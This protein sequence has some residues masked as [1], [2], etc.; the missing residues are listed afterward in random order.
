L[1]AA[2]AHKQQV[3]GFGLIQ[4]LPSADVERRL[5]LLGMTRGELANS[6]A[7]G[8]R[9][10]IL[11]VID[12]GVDLSAVGELV[13][14]QQTATPALGQIAIAEVVSHVAID[15]NGTDARVDFERKENVRARSNNTARN[16]AGRI[17]KRHMGI[18]GDAEVGLLLRRVG[19]SG[20]IACSSGSIACSS[21]SIACSSGWSRRRLMTRKAEQPCPEAA[22]DERVMRIVLVESPFD[23]RLALAEPSDDLARRCE[24]VGAGFCGQRPRLGQRNWDLEFE[25][26]TVAQP[27]VHVE[28]GYLID[29]APWVAVSYE[30]NVYLPVMVTGSI[31][32]VGAERRSALSVGG[33]SERRQN[34]EREE[35]GCGTGPD[36]LDYRTNGISET[37][38]SKH[39]CSMEV[40]GIGPSMGRGYPPLPFT[41]WK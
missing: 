38:L 8:K 2:A 30:A 32:V 14:G 29:P 20:S 11:R 24:T 27:V 18:R 41:F 37:I 10:G 25:L 13:A 33:A 34:G 40:R 1:E 26:D 22:L 3:E 39:V 36:D 16:G 7:D 12:F 5:A 6:A 9:V 31:R 21:G 28:V 19:S 17:V 15:A 4:C 23:S 35:P